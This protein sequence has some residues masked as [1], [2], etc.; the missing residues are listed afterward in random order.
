MIIGDVTR[1]AIDGQAL[2]PVIQEA[3]NY[4]RDTDFS[5]LEDGHYKLKGD[6]MFVNIMSYPTRPMEEG[7]FENH[8]KY[9]DVQYLIS[10]E[11]EIGWV[12]YDPAMTPVEDLLEEKDIAFYGDLQA[13]MYVPLQQGRYAIFFPD[14]VHQPCVHAQAG[15]PVRKAVIKIHMNLI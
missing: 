5:K 2:H 7:R 3:I 1:K 6:E 8:H 14:D 4:L 12:S 9:I 10:G 13:S 15:L 11:E